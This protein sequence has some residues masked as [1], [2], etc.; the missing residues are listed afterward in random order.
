MT[1]NLDFNKKI[2]IL[3][4]LGLHEN[5]LT[6]EPYSENYKKLAKFWSALPAYEKAEEIIQAIT[7]YS[8]ILL[9]GQ[10]GSGK[11]L[12]VPKLALHWTNYRGKI[13]MTLPKRKVTSA[14][15]IFSAEIADV[16]LGT[17]IGYQYKGS[18]KEASSSDNKILYLTDGLLI[19]RFVKDPNLSEF[20]V[21]II[22]EAHE[23]RVQID[24]LLLLLK[25]ILVSGKRPDLRVIIMSATIDTEKYR[26]YFEPVSASI[27]HISGQPNY[28]ITTV[29]LEKESRSYMIDGFRQ[30]E[31]LVQLPA[32]G[33]ILFFI[34]TSNEALQL[35]RTV[36]PKY[37]RVYCIEVYADMDSQAQTYAMSRD[38]YM[39]LG[40]YDQKLVIATNVA[41][42][43][44]TI[45]GLKYVIDSGYE[46][47]S[48]FD[49]EVYGQVLEKK[50][51]TKAQA[52]QRRGRVG[53]TA[54]GTC[55]H[56][57]T[58]SQFDALENYPQPSILREDITM[59]II[60]IMLSTKSKTLTEA[61]EYLS[62]L[63]DEPKKPFIDA[64][65][66][67]YILY[68]I[69]DSDDK[70]TAI[71]KEIAM[72]SS[73]PI[74]RSLFMIYA[75][76]LHCAREASTIVAMMERTDG[77][78]KN[79]FFKADTMCE[80]DCSNIRSKELISRL[81]Q[82]KGDHLTFLKF[83]DEY[84]KV[85]DKKEWGNMYGVRIQT[86][87]SADDLAK[88]YFYRLLNFSKAP[89]LSRVDKV[90]VKKNLL[91]ALKLSHQHLTA[92]KLQ[93]VFA[94]KEV[95]GQVNKDSVIYQHYN[96][97]NLA[98]KTFVYDDITNINGNWEYNVVTII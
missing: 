88:K 58:K 44:L 49:P 28:E 93:P 37:P 19:T 92:R 40:N 56:L 38:K 65:T 8:L 7:D 15:G 25:K 5:P 67:L 1:D 14:A 24:L 51:I 10:T 90:D 45:D 23:R 70:I 98:S 2:G 26:K 77:K 79:L 87:K 68:K 34:T 54:P 41:E 71:G 17:H 21:V 30:I 96:R 72:F 69:I 60:T 36:R 22:D 46:L 27:I 81:A 89:E 64:A 16:P 32:R 78:I 29:F 13:A 4:P 76:Q 20:K 91:T 63:M 18:P 31:E 97:Q 74:N 47:Y 33:D 48:Y 3:D 50:L 53:R 42:S 85:S 83:F 39:E 43:S 55:Y 82:K 66:D 94:K 61:K 84:K 95:T 52:L 75:F 62:E 57:L 6:G 86:L 12:I 35:C 59:N 9:V 73:V 80:T 11:S